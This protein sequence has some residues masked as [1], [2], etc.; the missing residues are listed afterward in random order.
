MYSKVGG[1]DVC[2]YEK[3]EGQVTVRLVGKWEVFP[4]CSSPSQ[5]MTS[6]FA[7]LSVF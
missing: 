2:I 6:P 5:V 7:Y 1:V 4:S 3:S